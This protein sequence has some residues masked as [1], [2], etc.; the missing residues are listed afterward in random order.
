[1]ER[2]EGGEEEEGGEE[3]RLGSRM[4]LPT[5]AQI[6]GMPQAEELQTETSREEPAVSMMIS[7]KSGDKRSSVQ[8]RRTIQRGGASDRLHET[9]RAPRSYVGWHL[10]TKCHIEYRDSVRLNRMERLTERKESIVS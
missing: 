2:G 3:A 4:H 8:K 7:P 10:S 9:D 5:P 6:S 1:M